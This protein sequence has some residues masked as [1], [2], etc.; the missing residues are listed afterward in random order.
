MVKKM[1]SIDRKR[2]LFYVQTLED[3]LSGKHFIAH[4]RGCCSG[5]SEARASEHQHNQNLK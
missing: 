5:S 1:A 3:P 2:S 4:T